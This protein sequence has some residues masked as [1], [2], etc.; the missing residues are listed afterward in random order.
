MS[1]QPTRG[2]EHRPRRKTISLIAVCLVAA[3]VVLAGAIPASAHAIVEST[4]PGID[5]VVDGAPTEVV[6]TFNEPVEIAFGAI[7]V[8]DTR[9]RRVEEGDAE[10]LPGQADS[11]RV[12][13]RSGLADGTYTVTW[14]VVS[15]DGHPIEEA[16]VF[17]VGA[18]GENP[19]GIADQILAGQ[20][21]AGPLE[22]VLFGVARWLNFA[23]LLVLAGTAVFL[24]VVWLHRR[25]ASPARPSEVEAR[26]LRRWRR[27]AVWSWIAVLFATV[28]LYVLQGAAAADVPL[29]EALSGEVIVGLASTRF[30]IVSLIK[31]GLLLALAAVWFVGRGRFTAPAAE[32]VGAS[33]APM[34]V[35]MWMVVGGLTGVVLLAAT[36]GVAGHA[37]TTPPVLANVPA[38][39]LHVVAAGA[40]VGGLLLLLVAAFPAVRGLAQGERVAILAPVVS[41]YSDMAVVAIGLLVASG[42]LRTWS[43]VRAFRAFTGA[44]YGVVLLVKLAAFLPILAMGA[45]NNRWTKPRIARAAAEGSPDRAPLRALRRLVA[46]EVALATVVIGITAFLVN[47]PPARVDAGVTGPFTT[48]VRLGSNNLNVLVDP[49]QVGANEVHLTATEPSGAPA[50]IEEMRVLFRMPSQGIG[51][52][53]G[54]GTELATG[55]FVVQGNHLSVAGEW[56]LEIVARFS[57]FEE[58]R[59]SVDVTVNP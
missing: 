27:V 15:A 57:E 29:G 9:G 54:K 24:V 14:R 16:F 58:E 36:P 48:D 32:S 1:P 13:L 19:L 4:E 10:H 56:R 59:T 55:H 44:T 8:F 12:G 47:L 28:A 49:N 52:L 5:Q 33:A 17:H 30:G 45:I 34:S 50:E 25:R 37:G 3:G 26:F 7:R 38:D 22:G 2:R 18:P 35:P 43:E 41:R 6:M 51:P 11:V 40:W 53:V 39:T 46:V 20:S 42:L 21:G 31:L 23:A